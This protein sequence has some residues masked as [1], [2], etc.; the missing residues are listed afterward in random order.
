MFPSEKVEEGT[1]K[2]LEWQVKWQTLKTVTL[3]SACRRWTKA[4][5]ARDS[6]DKCCASAN[7][8]GNQ[9]EYGCVRVA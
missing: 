7:S 1:G 6:L 5:H 3:N 4:E 2:K 8:H 9:S